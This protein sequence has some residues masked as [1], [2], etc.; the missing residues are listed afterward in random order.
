M[1]STQVQARQ[2]FLKR[3]KTP[4]LISL[5]PSPSFVINRDELSREAEL[6]RSPYD[7]LLHVADLLM[8]SPSDPMLK[9][10]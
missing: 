5:D 3:E 9:S 10:S 7:T 4:R 1:D 6:T 8:E 2:C